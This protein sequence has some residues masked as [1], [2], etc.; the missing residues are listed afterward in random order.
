V[1]NGHFLGT[2][3]TGELTLMRCG[4]IDCVRDKLPFMKERGDHRGD[5]LLE[6]A[7]ISFRRV[8]GDFQP[9]VHKAQG[10]ESAAV[11]S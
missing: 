4:Q 3:E 5:Q 7:H 11:A 1:I 6:P 9:P 8:P 2:Y 10:R